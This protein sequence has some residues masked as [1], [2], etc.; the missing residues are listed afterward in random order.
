MSIMV[1]N[2]SVF[3]QKSEIL[4]QEEGNQEQVTLN[5]FKDDQFSVCIKAIHPI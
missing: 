4:G 2:P 5:S 1:I 3:S